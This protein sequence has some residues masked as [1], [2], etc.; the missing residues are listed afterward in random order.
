M[1]AKSTAATDTTATPAPQEVQETPVAQ[2]DPAS[3]GLIDLHA[4][5]SAKFLL[6][7]EA[8]EQLRLAVL[9]LQSIGNSSDSRLDRVANHA[10][11][12]GS[13]I[14]GLRETLKDA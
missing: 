11:L 3:Q 2:V 14:D 5:T 4:D 13:Q 1:A 12:V 10:S 6:V 7:V 9:A 8:L